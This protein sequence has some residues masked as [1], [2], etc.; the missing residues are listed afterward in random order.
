MTIITLKLTILEKMFKV[1]FSKEK[2]LISFIYPFKQIICK[3][4]SCKKTEVRCYVYI[5]KRGR[6]L[7]FGIG[8][9]RFSLQFETELFVNYNHHLTR[10]ICNY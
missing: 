2:S 7:E 9:G 6:Q 3:K 10:K 8:Y 5:G 4:S 1:S